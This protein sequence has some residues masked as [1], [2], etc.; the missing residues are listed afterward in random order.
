MV[1]SIAILA[2]AWPLI[3]G[4]TLGVYNIIFQRAFAQNQTGWVKVCELC[5]SA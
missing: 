5:E 4:D 1:C 2:G 3:I